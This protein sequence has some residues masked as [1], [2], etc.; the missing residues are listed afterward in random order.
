MFLNFKINEDTSK[1]FEVD[2]THVR[3]SDTE[4]LSWYTDI[5]KN[6]YHR[7]GY[8]MGMAPPPFFATKHVS[9]IRELIF[10]DRTDQNNLFQCQYIR[11]NIP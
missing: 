10:G 7:S 8:I 11:L 1:C 9:W 2:V 6:W 5:G 3:S 4:F